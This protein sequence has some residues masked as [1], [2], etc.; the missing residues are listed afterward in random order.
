[1]L[2]GSFETLAMRGSV[3]LQWR[4][5]KHFGRRRNDFIEKIHFKLDK[6]Y[7]IQMFF[8]LIGKSFN[9]DR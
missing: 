8:R 7:R 3:Q 5:L 6:R 9:V 1:M 4:Y 2:L